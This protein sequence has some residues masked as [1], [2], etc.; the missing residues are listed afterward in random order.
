MDPNYIEAVIA[1]VIYIPVAC[2]K[3]GKK[4]GRVGTGI[5]DELA[6][7]KGGR[8]GGRSQFQGGQSFVFFKYILLL[9]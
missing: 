8:E 2:Y 6:R 3:K 9:L 4:E 1:V 7:G 5:L